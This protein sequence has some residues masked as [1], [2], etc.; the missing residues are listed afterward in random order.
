[1]LHKLHK[2]EF[3]EIERLKRF[4]EAQE[5]RSNLPEFPLCKPLFPIAYLLPILHFLFSSVSSFNAIL[6]NPR[7]SFRS[8][9]NSLLSSSYSSAC[10]IN[11]LT[12]S[13]NHQKPYSS[14]LGDN[15]LTPPETFRHISRFQNPYGFINFLD[16]LL[17]VRQPQ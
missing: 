8:S 1:M 13:L 17:K 11:G 16:N 10:R 6:N 5:R 7:Y 15:P 3:G 9:A 2:P 14:N 12:S 4:V